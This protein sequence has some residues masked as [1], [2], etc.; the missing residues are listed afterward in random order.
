MFRL[1][2][3]LQIAVIRCVIS[4]LK[5]PMLGNLDLEESVIFLQRWR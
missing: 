2:E 3:K 4:E 1:Y 5:P